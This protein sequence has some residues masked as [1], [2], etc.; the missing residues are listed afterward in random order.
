MSDQAFRGLDVCQSDIGKFI[1]FL[2]GIFGL[3]FIIFWFLLPGTLGGGKVRGLLS[4]L[5]LRNKGF[6]LVK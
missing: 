5:V 4:V 1:S 6:L 3:A 2:N